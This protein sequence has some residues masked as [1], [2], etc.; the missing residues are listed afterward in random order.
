MGD[1]LYRN[2]YWL[3]V[4]RVKEKETKKREKLQKIGK[5]REKTMARR[6]NTQNNQNDEFE[7]ILQEYGEQYNIEE[8]F[9][10]PNDKANLELLIRTFMAIKKLQTRF[11]SLSEEIGDPDNDNDTASVLAT[12]LKKLNDSIKDNLSSAAAIER[13]LGIDRKTRK[14]EKEQSVVE[15][16][17][18]LKKTA[19]A[20][21]D[22]DDRL[23][24]IYC[25][26]CNI[27]VGRVS[28]VY[29]TTYYKVTF[30]CPQCQ[31]KITV[32]RKAKDIFYDLPEEDREWRRKYPMEVVQPQLLDENMMDELNPTDTIEGELFLGEENQ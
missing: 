12:Q 10:N 9:T 14:S 11:D 13:Q 32:T 25:K 19:R 24:K 5:N 6:K 28:G 29:D 22:D 15:Y 1:F 16:I 2:N 26:A 7:R 3:F 20:F 23:K 18:W 21:L 4:N 8:D 30:Q 17:Q 31:N 27:M